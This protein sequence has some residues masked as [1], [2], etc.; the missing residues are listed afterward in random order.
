MLH[1]ADR[2]HPLKWRKLRIKEIAVCTSLHSSHSQIAAHLDM[3]QPLLHLAGDYGRSHLI[4]QYTN[5][6]DT[7]SSASGMNIWNGSGFEDW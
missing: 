3:Q 1:S 5:D 2:K 7:E 6:R 4:Y